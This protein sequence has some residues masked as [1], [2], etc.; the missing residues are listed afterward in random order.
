[1]R[2][3]CVFCSGAD[4][5]GGAAGAI[6]AS[7]GAGGIVLGGTGVANGGAGAGGSWVEPL[8]TDPS[9]IQVALSVWRSVQI[10]AESPTITT[11]LFSIQH[12]TA[13]L[14]DNASCIV[15]VSPI[16]GRIEGD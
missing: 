14:L 1:M 15:F 6:G 9:R 2:I 4:S 8:T 13:P 5:G 7:S 12:E 16:L 10:L 11:S 3:G